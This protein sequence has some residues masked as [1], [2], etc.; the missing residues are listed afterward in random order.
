MITYKF[1]LYQ[2]KKNKNLH[3]QIDI[4]GIVWNHFLALQKRYYRRY[5]KY[6]SFNRM[7][8]Y[9]TK[10]KKSNKYSYWNLVGSQALQDILKRLDI[11]YR[12]FFK[13]IAKRPPKFKKVK[14]YKSF[15]LKQAGY[16]FLENNKIK[17]S[18][19]TYRYFKSRDILGRIK[20]VIIKRNTT[21]DLYIFVIT[22]LEIRP[23]LKTT[24]GNTEGFDFGLKTFLTSSIGDKY[25]SPLF[26]KQSLSSLRKLSKSHSKK[27]KGSNN[28]NKSRINL[29]KLHEKIVNQRQYYF[30]KL[31]HELCQK[32]DCIIFE[33]LNLKGMVKLWGRKVNDLAF[34]KFLSIL[35][36]VSTKY[37]VTIKFIDRFYPSSKMC[38]KCGFIN[39][40]LTLSDREWKC[41][42]CNNVHDRDI[43]A[44]INIKRV[45]TSTHELGKVSQS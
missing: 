19:K 16:R 8:K 17:I 15:T 4:S 34:N 24:K 10:L 9:L 41:S 43:N 44:A 11:A 26:L 13:K 14:H 20:Q 36:W 7:C 12:R 29:A 45:G 21:G 28:R 5:N 22:D 23:Y 38:S 32:Y 6:I 27:K 2:S 37:G 31:A 40:D 39:R 25:K 1:K 42:E 35:Q 33:D 30:Y 3:Q 18:N